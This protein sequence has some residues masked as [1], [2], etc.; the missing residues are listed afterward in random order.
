MLPTGT[1]C[2]PN[3][4]VL[5]YFEYPVNLAFSDTIEWYSFEYLLVHPF[6]LALTVL[7]KN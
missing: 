4:P 7:Q 6:L 3:P 1:V 5:T 2:V